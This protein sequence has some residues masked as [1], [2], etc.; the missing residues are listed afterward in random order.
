M[1]KNHIYK[2]KNHVESWKL[3]IEELLSDLM[4]ELSV[5]SSF[6]CTRGRGLGRGFGVGL[7]D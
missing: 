4:F 3:G 1:N 7:T 6:F 5:V 2:K